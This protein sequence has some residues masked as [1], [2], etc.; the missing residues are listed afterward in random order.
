LRRAAYLSWLCPAVGL[1]LAV[2][3]GSTHIRPLIELVGLVCSLVILLSLI[4]G[5]VAL[6]GVREH[7]PQ[8]ILIPSIFGI[9]ISGLILLLVGLALMAGVVEG[10]A[11]RRQQRAKMIDRMEAG[12]TNPP[13]QS[14]TN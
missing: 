1:V 7:G 3:C 5:I 11:E 12:Q 6:C 14:H 13:P 8:G 9:S 4:L 10:N 2:V